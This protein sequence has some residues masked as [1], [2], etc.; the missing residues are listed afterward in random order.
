MLVTFGS[1]PLAERRHS[2]EMAFIIKPFSFQG[3]FL[4]SVHPLKR[5]NVA[6]C[7]VNE[8]FLIMWKITAAAHQEHEDNGA[9]V[10]V[11]H[12]FPRFFTKPTSVDGR[13]ATI[14][15][16][17]FTENIGQRNCFDTYCS[18]S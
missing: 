4:S 13:E 11:V 12:V 7:R 6:V 3:A 16:G 10:D 8:G 2:L 17:R 18:F 1:K 5:R 15:S 14:N 9:L